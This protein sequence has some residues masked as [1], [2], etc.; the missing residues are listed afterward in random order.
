MAKIDKISVNSTVY[1]IND[2][3]AVSFEAQTLTTAQQTQALTNIGAANASDLTALGGRM[4]SAE[5]DIDSL[6]GRMTNAETDIDVLDAGKVAVQQGS[7]NAGKALIVG[8]DGAVTTGDAGIPDAVKVAL[9]NLV[10]HVAYTDD[11]GQSYYNALY[12]ALYASD[13]PRITA[14]YA[15]GSHV[16]YTDDA[17]DTLK[18]YMTVTYYETAVSPGTTVAANAY[19]LSGML[20]E[21]EN[22]IVVQYNSLMATVIVT[23]ADWYNKSHWSLSNGDC[24]IVVGMVSADSNRKLII[25]EY[26]TS[27]TRRVI[28]V[29]RGHTPYYLST[30][31]TYIQGCYPI[32]IPPNANQVVVTFSPVGNYKYACRLAKWNGSDNISYTA[33]SWMESGVAYSFTAEDNIVLGLQIKYDDAGTSF[34]TEPTDVTI[35]FSAQ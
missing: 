18:Q 25:N 22:V 23:A 8:N 4:T 7:G 24:S 2:A 10:Q 29:N 5:T 17:L 30:T 31:G 3:K 20:T 35:E 14:V 26:Q 16:V 19:T 6:E 1:D 21:G 9:L 13:Y 11:Q 15:P 28:A 27:T 34:P 33:S 12:A 32:P